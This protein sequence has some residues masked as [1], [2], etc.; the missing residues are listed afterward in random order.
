M[1]TITS[2][3]AEASET[4]RKLWLMATAAFASTANLR[5]CDP[6]LP[7]IARAFE[8]TVGRASW[9]VTAY[10]AAYGIFQILLGPLGDRLGKFRIIAF[11]TL[12]AGVA[13]VLCAAMPGLASLTVMRFL[14]GASAAAIIPLSFAWIGDRVAYER[15]QV[16][17]SRFVSGQIFGIVFGQAIGGIIADVFSWRM[18]FVAVGAAHLIAAFLMLREF[19]RAPEPAPPVSGR[20]R[21]G[22]TFAAALAVLAR[23]RARAVLSTGLIEAAAMF[24]AMA[25]IGADLAHR[26]GVS[27]RTNG[28]IL[29]AYAAGALTYIAL[30]PRLL[31]RLGE[32]GLAI[33][34]GLTLAVAFLLLAGLPSLI[35]APVATGLLGLGYYLIHNTLQTNAT[36]MA[37]EARGLG[38]ALFA[39]TLFLGQSI[40]VAVAAPI[41]DAAGAWPIFIASAV[42]LGLTGFW[43][44]FL[45]RRAAVADPDQPAR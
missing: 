29:S 12:G 37:P 18:V 20:L 21:A 11:A 28:L 40:G 41:V 15:R 32:G 45:R 22:D 43:F 17:L 1:T 31:R 4:R 13:S 6:L 7:E 19:A 24:G 27:P 26:F 10:A 8:V 34:G 5:I 33:A 44:D 23:P 16:V 36:Q 35:F 39:M 14:A 25:F 3:A 9:I 42:I 2:G 30:A 38:V